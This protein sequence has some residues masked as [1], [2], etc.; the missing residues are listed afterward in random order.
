MTAHS[1]KLSA[2]V[3]EPAGCAFA[4]GAKRRNP[5]ASRRNGFRHDK[6]TCFM[7][8]NLSYIFLRFFNGVIPRAVLHFENG[9]YKVLR[10]NDIFP[11]IC[12]VYRGLIKNCFKLGAGAVAYHLRK[13]VHI[14]IICHFFARQIVPDN[15]CGVL[16]VGTFNLNS[17]VET[18]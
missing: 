11:C 10:L 3:N 14:N 12:G 7:E 16:I 2:M 6:M 15:F 17:P 18:A 5:H 13:V 1:G 4:R 9:S 8:R